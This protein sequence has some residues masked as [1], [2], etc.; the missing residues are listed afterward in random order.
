MTSS[1]HHLPTVGW[2]RQNLFALLWPNV[3]HPD[4][5]RR[6]S[7][8]LDVITSHTAVGCHQDCELLALKQV[9]A[10]HQEYFRDAEPESIKVL[11]QSYRAAIQQCL[12]EWVASSMLSNKEST[13]EVDY[14]G[15]ETLKSMYSVMHLA[16][17]FFPLLLS[18]TTTT[19]SWNMNDLCGDLFNVPGIA[20]AGLVRFLRYNLMAQI[21]FKR[22]PTIVEM[23]HSVYP[24]QF[25]TD[26]DNFYWALL[27]SEV[28]RGCLDNAWT[29]L[30]H[31]SLYQQALH[32]ESN[33]EDYISTT[34]ADVR[35]SFDLLRDILLR[36]PLPG[37]RTD[38]FD[39]AVGDIEWEE[40][41]D[42]AYGI[43]T[44]SIDV[45]PTDYKDWESI[46]SAELMM[47]TAGFEP[48]AARKH[49]EWKEYTKRKLR[50]FTL[51]QRH[52]PALKPI[53]AIL[54][55]D[56]SNVTF[57]SW[58][59]KLLAELLYVTPDIRPRNVTSRVKRMLATGVPSPMD[60]DKT[61]SILAIMDGNMGEAMELM[62]AF[63][64]GSGA[65]LPSTMVR[66]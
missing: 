37:G 16:D 18:R 30:S 54:C 26:G 20:T 10:Y 11:S 61:D 53:L 52:I 38:D 51:A 34:L 63:G 36:A 48:R 1:A 56:L 22:D 41:E 60:A 44:D 14:L 57:A 21:D 31:H 17:V 9:I 2:D 3:H 42:V 15:L 45:Q 59:G 66:R 46:A 62:Y 65:A 58:P 43:F 12:Q 35:E 40:E 39:D 27:E 29:I 13:D 23:L 55:G 6:W 47:E 50:N 5:S 24:E 4:Q 28:L 33:Q 64:G 7:L 19:S 32:A 8:S 25:E 49:K